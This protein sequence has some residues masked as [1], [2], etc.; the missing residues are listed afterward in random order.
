MRTGNERLV[1]KGELVVPV[2][3]IAVDPPTGGVRFVI[4][5]VFEAGAVD[6]TIDGGALW[7]TNGAATKWV[8][9]DTQALVGGVKRLIVRD[10][11]AKQPGRLKVVVK[12]IALSGPLPAP[13]AVRAVLVVGDVGECAS[14]VWDPPSGARP[15]CRGD[16]T[17]LVC[18]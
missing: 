1:L 17:R 9:K 7:K 13:D 8:Y 12:S 5:H 11:S 6:V 16:A 15:R 3:W 14:V 18:R 10:R 2:P 4:D